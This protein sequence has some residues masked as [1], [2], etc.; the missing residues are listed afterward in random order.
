[1]AAGRYHQ[2][3]DP[4]KRDP[5]YGNPALGSPYADHVIA[6]YEWK[7]DF[8]NVRVE[9]YRKTYHRLPVVDPV[10]WYRATGTG[11][12]TGVDVFV[13]GTFHDLNGWV[14]YGWLDSRRRQLDDPAE[15]PASG[16]VR[17]SLTLVGQYQLSGR[18]STG[19]RWTWT[20]GLPWT[21]VVGRT[22]DPLLGLWHPV[23]GDH[24][25]GLMPA[26]DR[27]DFRLMR[28]FSL[29]RMAGV[30]PSNVCVAYLE[31]MNVLDTQNVLN[32][33]YNSD[34]SR[35]Y[36]D[37]SYFSRRMLVAGFSLSW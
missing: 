7:S 37:Y 29:P 14:S 27:V 35:R 26:Y 15:V 23:Y 31:A 32:Y 20:S 10:T 17:H 25:S 19:L 34:Y 33:V 3:A 28:L 12:A 24:G 13:Q 9:G 22:W 21:P 16:A 4:A 6:G 30:R 8:G 1:V 5:L 18:W 36:E 11:H 2:L